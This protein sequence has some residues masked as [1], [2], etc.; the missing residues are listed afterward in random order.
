MNKVDQCLIVLDMCGPQSTFRNTNGYFQFSNSISPEFTKILPIEKYHFWDTLYKSTYFVPPFV[1]T[2]S[3]INPYPSVFYQSLPLPLLQLPLYRPKII[4]YK[5]SPVVISSLHQS[6]GLTWLDWNV[7]PLILA[8]LILS[9]C[10][11]QTIN[12]YH[13]ISRYT[14]AVQPLLWFINWKQSDDDQQAKT[15]TTNVFFYGR[16]VLT[17]IIRD[18]SKPEGAFWRSWLYLGPLTYRDEPELFTSE[19][20]LCH[21]VDGHICIVRLRYIHYI[22]QCD[23]FIYQI[24]I[25]GYAFYGRGDKRLWST[26]CITHI[27]WLSV[28]LNKRLFNL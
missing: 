8:T 10:N 3:H 9:N 28:C 17:W 2:S 24:Y 7:Y 18:D 14:C 16:G 19:C 1:V 25:L 13:F 15:D 5:S 27:Q 12:W 23:W 11:S 6:I 22:N 26:S 21:V 4:P 20:F